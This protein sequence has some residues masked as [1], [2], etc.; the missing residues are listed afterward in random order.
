MCSRAPHR[1]ATYTVYRYLAF[2]RY[3]GLNVSVSVEISAINKD[4]SIYHFLSSK[5]LFIGAHNPCKKVD[6]LCFHYNFI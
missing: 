1:Y 2:D 4:T 5:C 6:H 3:I